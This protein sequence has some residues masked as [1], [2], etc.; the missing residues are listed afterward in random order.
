MYANWGSA[1][2][3]EKT[4]NSWNF[5]TGCKDNDMYDIAYQ[6]GLLIT[7]HN[8]FLYLLYMKTHPAENSAYASY[9][10]DF[11]DNQS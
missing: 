9:M 6:A 2:K 7:I 11:K 3:L 4:K 1:Q 8:T 10:S 5:Q